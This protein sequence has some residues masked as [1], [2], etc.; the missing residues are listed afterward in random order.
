LSTRNRSRNDRGQSRNDRGQSV[1]EFALVLPLLV[2]LMVGIVDLAR[3]YTTM[4]SVESAAREAADYGTFGAQ[5]WDSAVYNLPV[6]GT[7]DQMKL[8]AC[9]A[10]SDLT[11]YVGP[12]TACTNPQFAYK[13]S[14]DKG[15]SWHD[16]DA[17]MDCRNTTRNPPCWVRV[18]L[19]YDFHLLVPLNFEAFGVRYG[20][21][22][23]INFTRTSV[24]PMT[25]LNLP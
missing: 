9:T 25:D 16:W 10:A 21:P 13:L 3:I 22:N 15:A 23:A 20:L 5:K 24:F 14:G 2:F 18:T 8:R 1:V 11:D 19:T 7:E 6:D 12:D 4:L 17:A